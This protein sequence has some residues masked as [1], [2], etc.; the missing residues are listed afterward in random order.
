MDKIDDFFK[1]L[2]ERAANPLISSFVFSWLIWNWR[3]P[4]VL[5]FYKLGDLKLDHF[6]SY[7]DFIT[8]Q[9]NN[10]WVA[11]VYPI[12]SALIYTF[13][14]PF[15]NNWI[16]IINSWFTAWKTTKSLNVKK[17]Y[18]VSLDNYINLREIYHTR[19]NELKIVIN[20]ERSYLAKNEDLINKI[21]KV[22]IEKNAILDDLNS[23]KTS[24]YTITESLKEWQDSN[25]ILILNGTWKYFF[26]DNRNN[27]KIWT[28]KIIVISS[29][30]INTTPMNLEK[31]QIIENFHCNVS[32][33]EI[34][35]TIRYTNEIDEVN[36]NIPLLNTLFY[37]E[38]ISI[39]E[40]FE[41]KND[42]IEYKRM[43]Y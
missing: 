28:S 33:K 8:Y 43:H 32:T 3:I 26:Y 2:K 40:G 27:S 1:D 35:F 24:L 29:G 34:I 37:K 11:F 15:I 23:S 16:T 17:T 5:F 25:N 12:I 4:L 13:I 41:N 7:I 22:E 9:L 38:D 42:K 21:A 10:K 39:L 19:T 14:Y 20:Q 31:S 6:N 18:T 36:Y 30:I